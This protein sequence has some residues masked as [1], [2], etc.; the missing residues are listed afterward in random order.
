MVVSMGVSTTLIG[1]RSLNFV[2]SEK[3]L[4]GN[5]ITLNFTDSLIQNIRDAL[6]IYTEKGKFATK[7]RK[8]QD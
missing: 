4:Q 5:T 7:A 8:F 1:T 3:K 6:E 2:K